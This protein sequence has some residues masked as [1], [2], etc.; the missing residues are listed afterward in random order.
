MKRTILVLALAFVML[1]ALASGAYAVR[2]D[3][4][5][6]TTAGSPHGSYTTNTQKCGVCHA[7]HHATNT[8]EVLLADT[9][10]NACVYCHITSTTGR[11]AIYNAVQANYNG[12][13][14]SNAHSNFGTDPAECVDCHQVHAASSAMTGITYLDGKIL[15]DLSSG[16][17][18]QSPT[19]AGADDD[20]N[21]T[22]FCIQCHGYYETAYDTG[23]QTTHIMGAANA[24][25]A[26]GQ[27]N[28]T[29]RVAWNAS[30]YCFSCHGSGDRDQ[31][32]GSV[33]TI[34]SS[35]PHFTAGDRFLLSAADS[36]VA[37]SGATNSEDDGVCLRC[38]TDGTNGIGIDF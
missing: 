24:S 4:T 13:D 35:W 5:Y 37:S 12:S 2:G 3:S 7:V 38:H 18:S 28:Y 30:T 11:I 8:G 27:A 36:T 9:V 23:A 14:L 16:A 31:A 6:L 25:Y 10:A 32:D 15:R 34:A 19:F 33:Q 21:I 20:A 1:L 29:G 17:T 22:Q 26:N